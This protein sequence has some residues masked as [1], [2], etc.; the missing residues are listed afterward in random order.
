MDDESWRALYISTR[1]LSNP[2]ERAALYREAA[3]GRFVPVVRGVYLPAEAWEAMDAEAR[4]LARLR[5]TE[6][7]RPGTVFSHLSAALIWGLPLVATRLQ[8]PHCVADAS[9]GGRSLNGLIRHTTGIPDDVRRVDGLSVTAPVPTVLHVAQTARPETSI[10]VLDV[11]F[12]R[13]EWDL[14]ADALRESAARLPAS[15]GPARAE[16]ALRFADARSGSPG[17]SLSR[18]AMWRQR[19][20]APDLQ[21]RFVDDR[22]F[23]GVVDFFWPEFGV[24]GEFDGVGKYLRDEMLNGRDPAGVVVDEKRRENRL[25]ALDLGVARWEWADALVGSRMRRILLDAGLRPL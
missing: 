2:G 11:A 10:P 23:V 16:W 24:V 7:L 5:A 18:V 22:G 1:S 17:E 4:H 21:R 12:A 14:D 20:P 13:A 25:R 15:A 8:V 6:I 19:L 3:R 9:S